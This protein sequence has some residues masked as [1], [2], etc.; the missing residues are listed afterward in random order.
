MDSI[1]DKVV[2]ARTPKTRYP[3]IEEIGIRFSPR[4]FLNEQIPVEDMNK[5]F[6]AARWTPSA[7][8]NQPWY[9]YWTRN[10]GNTFNKL[11]DILGENNKWAKTAAVLI[12]CT[13]LEENGF[14]KNEY[15]V[16]DLGAAVISLILQAQHL[17]YFARQMG[18]F[19]KE[20]AAK[21][22][23]TQKNEKPFIIIALGKIGDYSGAS[24]ELINKDLSP[25]VRKE[26]IAK[27]I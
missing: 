13:Y 6:E 15:A 16:Y 9:F 11:Y 24:E 17:G 5:I 10:P 27:E 20:K 12:V 8:N 22:V 19:D 26:Q 2:K 25:S 7:R 14:G 3:V 18:I 1:K 4:C 23:N 21:I